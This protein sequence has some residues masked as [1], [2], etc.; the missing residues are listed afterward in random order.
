M[1]ETWKTKRLFGSLEK[2]VLRGKGIDIGCGNDPVFP[3]CFAF[4]IQHGDANNITQYIKEQFDFV[5]SSH[6][7]EHMLNPSHALKQWWRL[8]KDG[9]YMYILVP[10]ED[11]YEQGNWPSIYGP[12][13]KWTFTIFKE[14]SWS[15]VSVNVIDL[16]REL[17]DCYPIRIAIQDNYYDYQLKGVDQTRGRAMAQI[18]IILRKGAFERGD[19]TLKKLPRW[20]KF[21]CV[22]LFFNSNLRRGIRGKYFE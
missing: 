7:L 3:N 10:D 15:P 2:R 21:F 6:C 4:D 16:I 8:V 12:D 18:Q 22:L 19:K 14:K 20:C 5:Y 9:A 17:P 1:T 13:H 11:L